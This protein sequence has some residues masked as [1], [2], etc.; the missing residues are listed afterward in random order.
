MDGKRH[1]DA[2][3]KLKPHQGKKGAHLV[4]NS[5]ENTPIKMKSMPPSFRP[6][7]IQGINAMNGANKPLNNDLPQIVE[8]NRMSNPHS[9]MHH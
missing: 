6:V 4:D 2:N 1:H 7:V 9:H 5:A 8:Q 3:F